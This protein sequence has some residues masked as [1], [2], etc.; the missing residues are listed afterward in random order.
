MED[1]AEVRLP[2]IDRF[3][4]VHRVKSRGCVQ[5]TLLDLPLNLRQ[6]AT[7]ENGTIGKISVCLQA[8]LIR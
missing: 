4:V 2:D 6:R 8:S 3:L 7:I 5:F 1:F